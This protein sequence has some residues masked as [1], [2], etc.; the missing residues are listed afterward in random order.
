MRCTVKIYFVKLLFGHALVFHFIGVWVSAIDV[1]SLVKSK[2]KLGD[3]A[4]SAYLHL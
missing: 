1:S 2:S 4:L 3:D